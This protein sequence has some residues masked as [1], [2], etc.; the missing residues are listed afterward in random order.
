MSPEFWWVLAALV[1]VVYWTAYAV[2]VTVVAAVAVVGV[3]GL[4]RTRRPDY[5]SS[6]CLR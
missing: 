3:L 2:A 1:G 6:R 4:A 5:S